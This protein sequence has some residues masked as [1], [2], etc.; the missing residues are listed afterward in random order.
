MRKTQKIVVGDY[1][2]QIA[3]VVKELC[4]L[5]SIMARLP[6]NQTSD[7]MMELNTYAVGPGSI[8]DFKAEIQAVSLGLRQ[9][10]RW[11]DSMTKSDD[12]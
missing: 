4:E 6:Q 9:Y 12:I 5:E 8:R 3:V 11:L 10:K 7:F 1:Y 2:K